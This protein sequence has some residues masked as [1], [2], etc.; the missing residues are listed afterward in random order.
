[1]NLDKIV[2]LNQTHSSIVK[3]INENC[4]ENKLINADGLV[5]NLKGVGLS[6]LGADCAPIIFYDNISKIVAACHAGWRGAV[7]N[8]VE[9]TV[10]CMETLGAKR[11]NIESVIGPTIQKDSYRIKEDVAQIVRQTP[12]FKKNNSILFSISKTEHF[13][14]LPLLIKE[15]LINAK[16]KKINNINIDTYNCSNLFFSH[17]KTT[18]EKVNDPSITGRHISIVGMLKE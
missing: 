1:M 18:H 17:R 12:F 3:I 6:I 5:T 14:D 10:A 13:F 8:I 7:N 2:K 15:S 11:N 4:D 9:S 16:V